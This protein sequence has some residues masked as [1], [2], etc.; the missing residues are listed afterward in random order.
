MSAAALAIIRE[1]ITVGRLNAMAS[2][3]SGDLHASLTRYEDLL[4]LISE[5]A[6]EEANELISDLASFIL[7]AVSMWAIE[8]D[9]NEDSLV[10]KVAD[11]VNAQ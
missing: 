10:D 9:E 4:D 7:T 2:V 3:P 8:T 6:D 1:A 5:V 11:E